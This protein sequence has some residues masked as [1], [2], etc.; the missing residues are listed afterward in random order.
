MSVSAAI[1]DAIL[2]IYANLVMWQHN[3]INNVS[4]AFLKHKNVCLALGISVLFA[5]QSEISNFLLSTAILDAVLN[6]SANFVI[7]RNTVISFVSIE[8]RDYKN[9]CLAL[10]VSLLSA[11]QSEI[12]NFLFSAA[13]LDAILNISASNLFPECPNISK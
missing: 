11:I 8:F 10:G 6:I 13:I 9:V 12:F 1:L 5:M 3:V 7:G 4:N 2:N